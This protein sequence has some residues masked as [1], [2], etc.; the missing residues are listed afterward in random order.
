MTWGWLWIYL[1]VLLAS[2]LPIGYWYDEFT[3]VFNGSNGPPAILVLLLWP[4]SVL[5]LIPVGLLSIGVAFRKRADRKKKELAEILKKA[6]K[7]AW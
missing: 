1:G 4:V 3:N 6:A 7:T 5:I 2:A